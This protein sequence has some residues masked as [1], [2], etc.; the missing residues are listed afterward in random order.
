MSR[1]CKQCKREDEPFWEQT[2]C[3]C[4]APLDA[5]T[6]PKFGDHR[7]ECKSIGHEVVRYPIRIDPRELWTDHAGIK[8]LS[9]Y[10]TGRGWTLVQNGNM[11]FRVMMLCR[12][13]I[14]KEADAQARKREYQKLC[15]R[16]AG[17]ESMTYAQMLASQ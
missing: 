2:P 1:V 13:C 14:G 9:A 7:P 6:E 3:S 16:A 17:L 8:R 5:H 11:W 4:G 10:Y 12:D 15:K